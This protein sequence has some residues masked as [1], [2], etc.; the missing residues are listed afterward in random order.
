[1]LR[2]AVRNAGSQLYVLV[3]AGQFDTLARDLDAVA[4][5]LE[6]ALADGQAGM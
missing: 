4:A 6:T 1:M 2:D 5:E 3:R